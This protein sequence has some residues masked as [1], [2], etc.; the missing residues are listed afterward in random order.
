MDTALKPTT[1]TDAQLRRQLAIATRLLN[2]ED[3]LDYS[4]HVSVR[5]PGRDALFI[6]QG[7]DP[8]SDVEPSR[9]LLVDFDGM[10]LEGAPGKPPIELPIHIEILRARPDVQ[11]VLHC[12]ME[13]A[14]LFTMMEGQQLLPMRAR[15]TRWQSGI[16]T[17]ADPS[18]I[19][20]PAQGQALAAT[21][22]PHHAA[23]IR[24]HGLVLVAESVPALA[25]DAIHFQENAQAQME[26]L[27]AGCRPMPLSPA[28]IEHI[29]AHEVRDYHIGKLWRYYIQK[30]RRSGDLPPGW[31]AED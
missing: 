1:Y 4:G 5:A 6:Q 21:L 8:R 19:K 31:D 26:V 28:E 27:T 22:G 7:T 29:V 24:S 14:F 30:A 20:Y 3:I 17:H 18:H 13:L 16:P 23:L 11:A 15:A 12:H 10:V 2:A 25:V 9:M